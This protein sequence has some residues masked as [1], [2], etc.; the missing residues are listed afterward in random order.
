[1]GI[2]PWSAAV[3]ILEN[4]G[5]WSDWISPPSWF[6]ATKKRTPPVAW[7]E[8]SDWTASA[9]VRIPWTPTVVVT[10]NVTEPK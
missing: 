10:M 4:P 5:P 8:A 1:M 3:G 9:T 2:R 7:A 6:A